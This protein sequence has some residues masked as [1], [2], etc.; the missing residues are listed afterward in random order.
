MQFSACYP[1]GWSIA[2]GEDG[3][4]SSIRLSFLAPAGSR[5]AGLRLISVSLSPALVL[6]SEEDF[7]H[8]VAQ[9]MLQEYYRTLLSHPDIIRVDGRKAV[10]VGYDA[11]VVLGREVVEVTRWLTVFQV[12]DQQWTIQVT[13]RSQYRDELDEI[14]G[15]VLAHF[16]LLGLE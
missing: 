16:H 8:H 5:G 7:V 2:R 3:D 14:R 9:W 12:E 6:D 10:D 15:H 11:P 1:E 13:G 4:A